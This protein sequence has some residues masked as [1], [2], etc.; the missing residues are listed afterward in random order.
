MCILLITVILLL[1]TNNSRK[2]SY[3]IVYEY[4]ECIIITIKCLMITNGS[5]KFM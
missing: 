5:N 3:T 1:Y 4:T 2:S